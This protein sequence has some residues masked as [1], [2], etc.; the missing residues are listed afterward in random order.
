MK[1]AEVKCAV[2]SERP[3]SIRGHTI[4]MAEGYGQV[5]E[6]AML[7]QP[8]CFFRRH[9]KRDRLDRGFHRR[10]RDPVLVGKIANRTARRD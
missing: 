7:T 10:K 6:L 2:I 3:S 1:G 9:L 4:G 5:I 8:E